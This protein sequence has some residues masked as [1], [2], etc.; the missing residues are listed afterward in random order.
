M[1]QNG[2]KD[3][4]VILQ[5][6]VNQIKNIKGQQDGA[7]DAVQQG[8][9]S[10]S[11]PAISAHDFGPL[12]LEALASFFFI[13]NSDYRIEYITENVT[14][15]LKY[16]REELQ[17]DSIFNYIHLGDHHSFSSIL[18]P[19]IRSTYAYQSDTQKQ[20]SLV[21]RM[22][23][24]NPFESTET[25]E[26]KQQRV[27]EYKNMQ[28]SIL[29]KMKSPE[30]AGSDPA[31]EGGDGHLLVCMASKTTEAKGG[32]GPG[33]PTETVITRLDQTGRIVGVETQNLTPAHSQHF[34]TDL[35]GQSLLGLVWVGDQPKVISHIEH[36]INSADPGPHPLDDI[37]LRGLVAGHYFRVQTRTKRFKNAEHGVFINAMHTICG[38]EVGLEVAASPRPGLLSPGGP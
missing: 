22:L 21:C 38:E 18:V 6:T 34:T 35:V 10:S 32:G 30:A 1:A 37:R 23:V 2:K 14:E 17:G 9:V 15:F 8:E 31:Q 11:R 33:A 3:K 29:K 26:E 36:V 12:L 13:V 20:R 5:E 27:S 4:C 24:K 19:M 16:R 25:M 7:T 28:L